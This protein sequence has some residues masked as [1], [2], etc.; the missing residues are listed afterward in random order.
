MEPGELDS[1]A[2]DRGTTAAAFRDELAALQVDLR[3]YAG[4]LSQVARVE[5]LTS[6][7]DA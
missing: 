1:N 3:H 2:A 7:E 5:N 6:L 4:L